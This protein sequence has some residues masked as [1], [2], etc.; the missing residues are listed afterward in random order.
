MY[1]YKINLVM[2]N[3]FLIKSFYQG[4]YAFDKDFLSLKLILKI[5]N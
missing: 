5:L 3:G 4:N 2:Y 1:N